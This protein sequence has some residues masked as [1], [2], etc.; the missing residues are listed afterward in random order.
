VRAEI[1]EQLHLRDPHVVVAGFDR[2]NLWLGVQT[3]TDPDAKREA[4]VAAAAAGAKPGLV[5]T[6]TRKES[7]EYADAL[8][9]LGLSAAAYHAGR[10][11]ADRT[12]VHEAFLSG[13]LDVVVATTTFGMGIDKADVRFV[14]HATIADSL[15]SYYQE[16]GRAG[17]NGQ[18]AE[19][20][21]H[22]RA[23]DVGLRRFF[24]SGKADEQALAQVQ[25]AVERDDEPTAVQ[26]VSEQTGL[27]RQKTTRAVSLL[28]QVGTVVLDEQGQ[29]ADADD[30][31][32][33]EAAQDAAE[34]AES[35][36]KV[37]QSRVDMMRGYAETASCRR[38]YL[39]AYFGETLDEPCGSCDTCA[40][41]SAYKVAHDAED[42]PFE[43]NSRVEHREFGAGAVMRFEGD[44]IVVLFDEVGYRT[45]QLDVVRSRGL[46]TALA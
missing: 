7:E 3:N 14:L 18:P 35:H 20:V 43:I 2:P 23:E 37:E 16:I 8:A 5:C 40:S 21:L 10:K 46:L 1:A 19:A 27:S 30:R 36:R 4:V 11:A 15:D 42:S 44:R 9:E 39:L 25:A 28:E 33:A 45:L 26:D 17:R 32:P 13:E 24:A 12:A 38:Q 22:Y 34:V 29:L 31:G 41:G 6:A